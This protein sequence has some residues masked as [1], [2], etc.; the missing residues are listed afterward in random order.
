[1]RNTAKPFAPAFAPNDI[2]VR[3]TMLCLVDW[4]SD[5]RQVGRSDLSRGQPSE[6]E[7]GLGKYAGML[8][9][10]VAVRGEGGGL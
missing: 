5:G 10:L 3:A 2:R 7:R 8:R 1:M 4:P 9:L 6:M